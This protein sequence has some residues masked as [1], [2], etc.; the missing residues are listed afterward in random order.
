[1]CSIEG[2]HGQV[3]HAHLRGGDDG[4]CPHWR[5]VKD[6]RPVA[7]TTPLAAVT[8]DSCLELSGGAQ[9]PLFTFVRVEVLHIPVRRDQE[10][11]ISQCFI[12]GEVLH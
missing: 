3:R 5:V 12:E 1:M 7:L 10:Q 11:D 9:T 2:G 8:V 6:G 4:G